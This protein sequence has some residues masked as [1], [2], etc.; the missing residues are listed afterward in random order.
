[1]AMKDHHRPSKKD[2]TQFPIEHLDLEKVRTVKELVEGMKHISFQ[3]RT[4]GLVATVCQNMAEDPKCTIFLGAAGALIPGGLRKVLRDLVEH[5]FVDVIVTTGAI[6]YHDW[7][8]AHG[9]RHYVSSPDADDILLREHMLD[10]VYDTLADE[11][12]F[13]E[14]DDEIANIADNLEPRPYSS[15]EF[16]EILGKKYDDPNSL[17]GTCAR[18]G[19]PYFVPALNDSSVG[20]ALT[21]HY[22]D[23]RKAKKEPMRIDP[24]R[25]NYEITQIKVK[26]PVTGVFYISGGTPKNYISQTEVIAEVL[27][28]PEN[29]HM[30]AAQITTDVPQWGGLSGCTF[31]ESQSWGKFHKDAKMAQC[32]VEATIGLPLVVAYLLQSGIKRRNQTYK[33]DGDT[34]ASVA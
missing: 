30:Y 8:E 11:D 14:C 7:Y 15:R 5:G 16:L 20:I 9:F 29:P 34:L 18:K 17:V 22:R 24:I 21:K 26:S 31:E 6:A 1:M 10:R 4:L 19:V 28:Y 2:L 13:R 25:D 33:W 23:R 3:S 27:G 12:L 32:L